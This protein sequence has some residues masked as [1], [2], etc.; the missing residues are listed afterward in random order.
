[1]EKLRHVMTI[2]NFETPVKAKKRLVRP[3]L[4]RRIGVKSD[5][6][7]LFIYFLYAETV[8]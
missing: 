4:I 2:Q 8:D 6:F 1:M 5:F 3:P 7:Y